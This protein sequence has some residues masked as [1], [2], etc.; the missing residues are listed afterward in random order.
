MSFNPSLP[1]DGSLMVAAEMRDQF[2]GLNLQFGQG[3]SG[4]AQNPNMSTLSIPLSDPPTRPEVQQIIDAF[5][6]LLNQI[7]RV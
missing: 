4:T 5:D 3:L 7:T 2:N 6:M 1:V